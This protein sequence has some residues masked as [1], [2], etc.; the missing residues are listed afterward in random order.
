M[1][2]QACHECAHQ[3]STEATKCPNC[4]ARLKEDFLSVVSSSR[5]KGERI[6]WPLRFAIGVGIILFML[7][8]YVMN[9]SRW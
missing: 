8:L 5:K 2:L 3:V 6:N 4:G 1:A 9:G 7:M